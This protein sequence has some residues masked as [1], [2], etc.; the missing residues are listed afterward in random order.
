MTEGEGK[1]VIA[2]EEA[3]KRAL[4]IALEE[5]KNTVCTKEDFD[6]ALK[7]VLGSFLGVEANPT[8]CELILEEPVT[9]KVCE[10]F[11]EQRRW[12]MCRTHQK[13]KKMYEEGKIAELGEAIESAWDELK[14]KCLAAGYP[15]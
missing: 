4:N 5:V 12:V 8:S 7:K 15:V 6:K 3:I 13:L 9:K 11:Y 10:D 1:C 2:I 14:E